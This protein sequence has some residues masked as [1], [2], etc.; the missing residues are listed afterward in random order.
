MTDLAAGK[1]VSGTDPAKP[2]I[3]GSLKTIKALA[4][5]KVDQVAGRR[6]QAEGDRSASAASSAAGSRHGGRAI[7]INGFDWTGANGPV[8]VEEALRA[9]PGRLVRHR[10]PVPGRVLPQ[11][12]SSSTCARRP[13]RR[14]PARQCRPRS[15]SASLKKFVGTRYTATYKDGAWE[16]KKAAGQAISRLKSATLKAAIAELNGKGYKIYVFPDNDNHIHIQNP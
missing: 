10:S 5:R 4:R 7:D 16:E 15:P 1:K 13:P 12:T 2:A 11:A 9:L 14:R 3:L 8:Q 6:D